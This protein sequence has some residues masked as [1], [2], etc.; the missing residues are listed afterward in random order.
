MTD[1]QI[2]ARKMYNLRVKF[3][4]QLKNTPENEIERRQM[5]T[6][7]VEML[8]IIIKEMRQLIETV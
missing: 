5:I 7:K 6:R 2:S 8:N 3:K 4:A 1:F